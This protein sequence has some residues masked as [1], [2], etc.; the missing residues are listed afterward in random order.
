MPSAL[1][2]L[3]ILVLAGVLNLA[4]ASAL[5]QDTQ[6]PAG[7]PLASRDIERQSD[8]A[9]DAEIEDRIEGIFS[10]IEALATVDVRV[11]EGVVTL[12]G[13]VPT[14][15][16]V[17]RAERLAARISGVVTIENRLER[18][19]DVETS[20][21]PILTD[22]ATRIDRAVRA[23]PILLIALAVGLAIA[24]F[25]FLIAAPGRLWLRLAPNPFV[26]GLMRQGVR[27]LFIVIAIVTGL[28]LLGAVALLGTLAGGAGIIGIAI[29]FAVRDAIENYVASIMLSLRQPFR[30]QDHVMIDDQEGIVI[31]LTS[32]S[33]VLMT[34]DG[35][36]LR[37]PNAQVFKAVILN[38]SRNPERRFEFTLGVDAEDD[39]V[40]AMEVGLDAL[41]QLAFILRD[42]EPLAVVDA[43]GDSNIALTFFGWINQRETSFPKARSLA[44]RAVKMAIEAHGFTLPEPIYRLRIDEFPGIALSGA[45]GALTTQ[46]AP[47]GPSRPERP[48]RP[49]AA[50][51]DAGDFDVTPDTHLVEKVESE[52]AAAPEGDLL[53]EDRPVE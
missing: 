47:A 22:L 24:G 32:R 30:A 14:E 48:V 16:A 43:V 41:R 9:L 44:I 21:S 26:A 5:A 46:A 7:D 49:A 27:V 2:T 50:A 28:S 39:P 42:P 35:N 15:A 36:H 20:V 38:Y 8:A 11:N 23:W 6:D 18:S 40:E 45:S 25:G 3:R 51:S 17:G 34:L 12:T 19:L 52:R 13:E 4:G 37:I 33:T 1:R 31:R 53:D 10:E 29:G